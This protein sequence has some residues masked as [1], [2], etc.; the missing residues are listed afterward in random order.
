MNIEKFPAL[1]II[2]TGMFF[3]MR[4]W[5]YKGYIQGLKDAKRIIFEE[6]GKQ[7]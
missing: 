4:Y 2:I 1:C 5:Y 3:C 6:L 7:K